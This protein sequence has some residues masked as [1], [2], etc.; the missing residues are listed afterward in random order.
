[1]L[2]E[3]YH[4][5]VLSSLINLLRV[6]LWLDYLVQGVEDVGVLD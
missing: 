5:L 4:R 2:I 1:M 3:Q 6:R